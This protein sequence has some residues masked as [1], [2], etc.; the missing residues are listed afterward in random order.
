MSVASH[1]CNEGYQ[2]NAT[3]SVRVCRDN[4]VWSG[5]IIAC[6]EQLTDVHHVNILTRMYICICMYMCVCSMYAR[7][8]VCMYG[9]TYVCICMYMYVCM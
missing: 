4:G 2:P 3:S 6:G 8:C 9:S 1:V 5:T 7:M